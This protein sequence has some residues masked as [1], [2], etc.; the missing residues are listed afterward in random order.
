MNYNNLFEFELMKLLEAEVARLAE[1]ITHPSVVV[2]YPDYKYQI[3]KI[4][5]MREVFAMCEE[6]NKTISER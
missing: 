5:G 6:V 3:G 1:N 2:D 4:A